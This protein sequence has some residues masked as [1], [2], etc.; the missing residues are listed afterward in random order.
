MDIAR[1]P[2]QRRPRDFGDRDLR[3]AW[4]PVFFRPGRFKLFHGR[5][6]RM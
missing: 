3:I 4:V 6:S 5:G 1:K 2:P